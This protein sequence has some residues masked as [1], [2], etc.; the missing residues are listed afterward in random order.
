MSKKV[1]PEVA[2]SAEAVE[3]TTET[4]A[5]TKQETGPETEAEAEA[6]KTNTEAET[7][8]ETK[9]EANQASDPLPNV[10]V[11]DGSVY[12]EPGNLT[13]ADNSKTIDAWQAKFRLPSWRFAALTQLKQWKR[14]KTVTQ[15][16]FEAALSELD[17]RII[18][19]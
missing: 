11:N 3:T 10:R 8:S 5:E 12:S 17:R 6:A 1:K 18:G 13:F 16:E 15:A 19:G 7:A 9:A 14:G 2:A 4:E